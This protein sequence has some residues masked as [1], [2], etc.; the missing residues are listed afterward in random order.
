QQP[1]GYGAP[2]GLPQAAAGM[3]KVVNALLGL[4]EKAILE[5]RLDDAARDIESARALQP[6][7]PQPPAGAPPAPPRR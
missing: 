6:A 3:D 7:G 5:G 4:T 1:A 2:P